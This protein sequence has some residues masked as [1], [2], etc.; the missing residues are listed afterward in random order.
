M[1][2]YLTL[3]LLLGYAVWHPTSPDLAA[4]VARANVVRAGGRILWWTGWFGG[5][6]LPSY[7][8]IVPWSMARIGVHLTG[9]AAVL[10][11]SVA[12]SV[13]ARDARR[14]R[15]A[16]L[17]YS[18]ACAADLLA[19][20]VTFAVGIAF[21]TWSLVALRSR[22]GAVSGVLGIVAILCSP[23]AALF[24]GIIAGAVLITDRRR[25]VA[26]AFLVLCLL[27][28]GIAMALLFPGTGTM[29]MNA[30]DVLACGSCCV[31]LYLASRNRI[32]RVSAVLLGGSLLVLDVWP[33][34][35]G[36]N[37]TR[38][39]WLCA[40]PVAAA[41]A[42]QNRRAAIALVAALTAWPAV[43]LVEQ[44]ATARTP[45]SSEAFYRPL[46]TQL[47]REQLAAG[48]PA[49]GERVE[50]LDTNTHW[51]SVYVAGTVA[52]ARGWD[53]Q[54]DAA[55]NPIFYQRGAI[56][57]ASYHTWLQ[58]LAVGWIAVPNARL[59]SASISEAALIGHGL[60]Y[61]QPTWSSRDW[62]L[63]HV[64]DAQPLATGGQVTAVSAGG[65]TVRIP[66]GGEAL[67]RIRYSRYLTILSAD[68]NQPTLGCVRDTAGWTTITVPTGGTFTVTSAFD[69]GSGLGQSP[70]RC[71]RR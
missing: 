40:A 44:L 14:P 10:A 22:Y 48:Q 23:L 46:L 51:A 52:I 29:P 43:D 53:R 33:G 13:L 24:L 47:A 27:S 58:Q 21:A 16:A 66:A 17:A 67:L 39:L 28:G 20:R 69:V 30:R 55:D 36:S 3:L 35:V 11:S 1:S 45:S 9:A 42:D 65:V 18:I 7:S 31:G 56:T 68:T 38:M 19:G 63:Y 5:L 57:P 2:T 4:Q 8:V 32:V 26:A 59:D 6:S 60:P 15:A 70:R 34:A 12:G 25:R 71:G 64:T 37:I 49:V 61:L 62:T 54:A 41:C 50:V